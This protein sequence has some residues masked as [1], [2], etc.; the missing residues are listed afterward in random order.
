MLCHEPAPPRQKIR[1]RA[2]PAPAAAGDPDAAGA[3][4][5]EA[6][7]ASSSGRKFRAVVLRDGKAFAGSSGQKCFG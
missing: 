2:S 3:T 7:Q 6:A 4:A 5:P 1:R